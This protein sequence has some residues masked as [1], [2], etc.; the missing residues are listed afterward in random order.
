[1][2][3]LGFQGVYIY[4]YIYIYIYYKSHN[5]KNKGKNIFKNIFIIKLMLCCWDLL[6]LLESCVYNKRLHNRVNFDLA[7]S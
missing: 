7:F 6:H 5:V 2:L 3:K 1:M 4:I